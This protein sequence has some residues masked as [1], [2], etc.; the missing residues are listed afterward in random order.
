VG[1]A[2]SCHE[3]VTKLSR[4]TRRVGLADAAADAAG[5]AGPP[6]GAASG[7]GARHA[8]VCCKDQEGCHG[9]GRAED[10]AVRLVGVAPG[11][12]VVLDTELATPDGA[13]VQRRCTPARAC[14]HD[15]TTP[16]VPARRHNLCTQRHRP[17]SGARAA[18][19][20]HRPRSEPPASPP[21]P[22][23][24]S[25][26]HGACQHT[27]LKSRPRHVIVT[28]P[29]RP[30]SRAAPRPRDPTPPD[31]LGPVRGRSH[32]R[33]AAA[34]PQPRERAPRPKGPDFEGASC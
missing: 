13:M 3:A 18:D 25:P 34:H 12:A 21:A 1:L 17:P 5:C 19:F 32:R 6:R 31:A 14:R 2:R 27:T 10:A 30:I 29:S 15:D 33:V 4:R 20:R 7:S 23:S 24:P 11:G 9:A 8:A 28:S 22:S 26:V 16:R